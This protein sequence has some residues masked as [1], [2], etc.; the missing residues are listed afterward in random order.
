MDKV[1]TRLPWGFV[2]GGDGKLV[3]NTG[4]AQIHHRAKL[5]ETA[6]RLALALGI[7]L[8]VLE[9]MLEIEDPAALLAKLEERQT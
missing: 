5:G 3:A 4:Q 7:R 6:I 9:E 1:K 8:E 2:V